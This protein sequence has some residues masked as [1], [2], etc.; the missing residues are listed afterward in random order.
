MNNNEKKIFEDTLAS[1][2][3][4][5]DEATQIMADIAAGDALLNAYPPDELS[6]D[7]KRKVIN[8]INKTVLKHKKGI[9]PVRLYIRI[10]ALFLIGTMVTYLLYNEITNPEPIVNHVAQV[11]NT[12]TEAELISFE[13]G[14]LTTDDTTDQSLDEISVNGILSLWEDENWDIALL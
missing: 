11:N 10:A 6:V 14:I 12:H 2:K 4:S 7:T 5:E 8:A 13:S 9:L 3:I 1:L